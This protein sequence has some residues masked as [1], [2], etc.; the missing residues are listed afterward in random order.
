MDPG[1]GNEGEVADLF[2][3]CLHA[4]V[5]QSELIDPRTKEEYETAVDKAARE[6][7][8]AICLEDRRK[9]V[10]ASTNQPM[11]D[12]EAIEI[13]KVELMELRNTIKIRMKRAAASAAAEAAERDQRR[14]R[15]EQ[16]RQQREQ[17]RRDEER[18]RRDREEF[19]REQLRRQSQHRRHPP[20]N[21]TSAGGGGGRD[22]WC[23]NP[24][25]PSP[26]YAFGG[27]HPAW[28]G[29][30][31]GQRR[32][33]SDHD[34]FASASACDSDGGERGALKIP[35]A[36]PPKPD[37]LTQV[38]QRMAEMQRKRKGKE[39][40]EKTRGDDRAP[41]RGG[42]N[43]GGGSGGG[44]RGAP[45][46]SFRG[47]IPRKRSAAGDN[48]ARGNKSGQKQSNKKQNVGE[49]HRFKKLV[50]A[51]EASSPPPK[52]KPIWE[53]PPGRTHAPTNSLPPTSP[54]RRTANGKAISSGENQSIERS[55]IIGN[56]P[57]QAR[58]TS[59]GAPA[60]MPEA[61][62]LAKTADT[63]NEDEMAAGFDMDDTESLPSVSANAT[64][65]ESESQL[66]ISASPG[67][68]VEFSSDASPFSK[69]R[70]LKVSRKKAA[71]ESS[72][73]KGT[74][75][76][77]S[78]DKVVEVDDNSALP[79]KVN[80]NQDALKAKKRLTEESAEEAAVPPADVPLSSIVGLDGIVTIE[81]MGWDA[82]EKL[83][84][85]VMKG[86]SHLSSEKLPPCKF[87]Y[88]SIRVQ[89][90]HPNPS[91]ELLSN[92][93]LFFIF[94]IICYVTSTCATTYRAGAYSYR[95]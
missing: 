3:R 20:P 5:R 92:P 93:N 36:G 57:Q 88:I 82:Y 21:G 94:S 53:P 65:G 52:R 7:F 22:R 13:L 19:E 64:L 32:Q 59:P 49:K 68:G 29:M 23:A 66:A 89:I 11:Q 18:A 44:G 17:A 83:Q 95:C 79:S 67:V 77:R 10:Q 25:S 71:S 2:S 76:K 15:D 72:S 6:M 73:S 4:K 54:G 46:S 86:R 62:D 45:S 37:K 42:G 69:K 87:F 55:K 58:P 31:M 91:L 12:R 56:M 30:G 27:D 14:Q 61:S 48:K 1:G 60:E 33:G 41:N 16:Q 70:G 84:N 81:P 51:T 85:P 43:V 38:R 40:E 75:S 50:S 9:F 78:V 28:G 8:R 90:L 74:G 39:S 34:V 24:V 80:K 47:H 26:A 63:A 35:A